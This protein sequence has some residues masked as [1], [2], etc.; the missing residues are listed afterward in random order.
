MDENTN[1][2]IQKKANPMCLA[3]FILSLVGLLI[4]GIPCGIAAVI[5]G[6][7]GLVKFDAEN[8]KFKWMGIV[9]MV[10]GIADVVLVAIALPTIIQNMGL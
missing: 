5:T 3:S 6:I 10:I 1:M 9:G 2:P 7:I 4:A 8:H